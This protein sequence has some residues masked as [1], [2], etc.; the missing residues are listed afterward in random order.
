MSS[1]L[2][3]LLGQIFT[4]AAAFNAGYKLYKIITFKVLRSKISI[5]RD[6]I[7]NIEYTKNKKRLQE[8][9]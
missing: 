1:N 7:S 3:Q 9:W 6:Q 8:I 2:K 5:G 4:L